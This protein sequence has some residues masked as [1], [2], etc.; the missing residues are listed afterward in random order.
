MLRK[1]LGIMSYTK[2]KIEKRIDQGTDRPDFML[3]VLRHNDEKGM[4]REDIQATFNVLMV[5]GSE[6][7]ATLLARYTYLL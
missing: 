5:A 1:Q 2:D 7:T 4:S 3:F 6:T